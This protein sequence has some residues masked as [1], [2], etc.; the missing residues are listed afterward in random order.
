MFFDSKYFSFS[1]LNLKRFPVSG[2]IAHPLPKVTLGIEK[3]FKSIWLRFIPN[4]R[5][6]LTTMRHVATDSRCFGMQLNISEQLCDEQTNHLSLVLV[7]W[8][9]IS[10]V[11]LLKVALQIL[12]DTSSLCCYKKMSSCRVIV[13]EKAV[14]KGRIFSILTSPQKLMDLKLESCHW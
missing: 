3:A 11:V 6:I 14:D 13:P 5:P 1:S 2:W 10:N 9:I 8:S 4:A 12:P 7:Y